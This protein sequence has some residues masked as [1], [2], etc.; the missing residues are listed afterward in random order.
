MKQKQ[1]EF[2]N[3]YRWKM[4]CRESLFKKLAGLP[5][6]LKAANLLSGS[7]NY[8]VVRRSLRN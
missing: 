8:P 2:S 4:N 3:K 1:G 5:G 6:N 7:L